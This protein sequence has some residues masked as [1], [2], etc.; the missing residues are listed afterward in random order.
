MNFHLENLNYSLWEV[1]PYI[2]VLLGALIG[3]NVFVVLI[4]GIVIS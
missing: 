4:S 3:I 1:L 2:V